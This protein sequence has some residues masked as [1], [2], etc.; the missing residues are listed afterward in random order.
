MAGDDGN[1]PVT[2]PNDGSDRATFWDGTA[3]TRRRQFRFGAPCLELPLH[4]GDPDVLKIRAVN[5]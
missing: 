4:R 2:P 3:W 5:E 1:F